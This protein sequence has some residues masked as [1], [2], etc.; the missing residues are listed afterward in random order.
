MFNKVELILKQRKHLIHFKKIHLSLNKTEDL[1][2]EIT[3]IQKSKF[4]LSIHLNATD[5]IKLFKLF[6][7]L[8]HIP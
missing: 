8:L 4:L 1:N 5:S 2:L 7:I 6:I 3:A